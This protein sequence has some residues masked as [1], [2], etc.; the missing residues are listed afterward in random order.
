MATISQKK[1][2]NSKNA[3]EHAAIGVAGAAVIAGVAVA[4]TMALKDK[5]T[6]E[7]LT[8][9]LI[10]AKN[11]AM[12]YVSELEVQTLETE[13]TKKRSKSKVL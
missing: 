10:N 12:D 11:Q 7:R 5:K 1:Q 6:K 2:D 8:K 3:M 9:V 13:P 4:A